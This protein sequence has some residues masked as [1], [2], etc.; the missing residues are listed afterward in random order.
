MVERAEEL[1]RSLGFQDLRVRHHEDP[2]PGR[3]SGLR[4]GPGAGASP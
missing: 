3:S 2:R 1:L 4:A